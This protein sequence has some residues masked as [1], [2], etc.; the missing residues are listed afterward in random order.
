MIIHKGSKN[1]VVCAREGG[2]NTTPLFL[3]SFAA[4]FALRNT[5][6]GSGGK[7]GRGGHSFSPHPFFFPPRPSEL[8]FGARNAPSVPAIISL[9]GSCPDFVYK[10]EDPRC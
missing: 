5:N 8:V 10:I 9:K 1:S 7:R 4:Y 3:T 6:L 2:A